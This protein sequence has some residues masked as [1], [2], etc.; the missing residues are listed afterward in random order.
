LNVKPEEIAHCLR[1]DS[2]VTVCERENLLFVASHCFSM[3]KE[4]APRAK[5]GFLI[6][7]CGRDFVNWPEL[8]SDSRTRLGCRVLMLID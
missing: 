6:S 5:V 4:S 8:P 1:Y 2:D 3:S 7:L